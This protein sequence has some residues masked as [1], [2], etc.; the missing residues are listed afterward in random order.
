MRTFVGNEKPAELQH[1]GPEQRVEVRDVF[2]N[3]MV[4]LD[5]VTPPPIVERPRRVGRHHC[6][7]EAMY[8]IGASNQT[9]Q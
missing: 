9:Y 1:A 3:E 5:V 6:C 7:V 8:P 4:D 2:A